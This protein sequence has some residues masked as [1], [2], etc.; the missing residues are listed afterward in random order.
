MLGICTDAPDGKLRLIMRVCEKGGLDAFLTEV[1]KWE[2]RC[3]ADGCCLCWC[4]VMAVVVVR[5]IT[6]AC[7]CAHVC[8]C[9][10]KCA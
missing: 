7:M 1:V 4:A 9:V 6:A 3:H 8:I 5:E 10:R 2:V